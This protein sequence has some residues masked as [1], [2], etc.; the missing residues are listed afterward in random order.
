MPLS[1]AAV[2]LLALAVLG[3]AAPPPARALEL[4][5][6]EARGERGTIGYI[7]MEQVFK[8]FPKTREAKEAFD[9]EVKKTKEELQKKRVEV[10]KLRSQIGELEAELEPQKE[11]LKD[12]KSSLAA[13][14]IVAQ[15]AR[16][17][18]RNVPQKLA[19]AETVQTQAESEA[20][21]QAAQKEAEGI[22]QG[23]EDEISKIIAEVPETAAEP[24]SGRPEP[25]AS[26]K[27]SSSTAGLEDLRQQVQT[28]SSTV[29]SLEMQLALKRSGLEVKAAALAEFQAKIK[30]DLEGL[31]KRK[32]QIVLGKIYQIVREIAEE[33]G[34]SVVVDKNAILYGQEAVDLTEKTL[35]K[36]KEL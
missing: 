36:I 8:E 20:D 2:G 12:L 16:G 11:K 14:T 22:R 10:S 26:V 4:E 9:L 33:E 18:L 5:L 17:S 3:P 28:T 7:D 34:I 13:K 29:Q 19:E 27:T 25:A 24:Q 31:E 30:E 15:I 23:A 21:R 32:I 6:R 35:A 1:G